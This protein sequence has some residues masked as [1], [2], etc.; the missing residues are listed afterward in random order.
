MPGQGHEVGRLHPIDIGLHG[1]SLD[2]FGVAERNRKGRNLADGKDHEPIPLHQHAHPLI[3]PTA[4]NFGPGY[5]GG[6]QGKTLINIPE[7]GVLEKTA[8]FPRQF[9]KRLGKLPCP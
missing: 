9:R 2:G 5:V 1:D 6:G 4:K 8:G 3:D 7:Q